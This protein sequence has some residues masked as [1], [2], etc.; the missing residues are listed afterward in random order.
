MNRCKVIFIFPKRNEPREDGT[1]FDVFDQLVDSFNDA[2]VCARIEQRMMPRDSTNA[3][4]HAPALL[5]QLRKAYRE[6]VRVGYD[7]KHDRMKS[8]RKTINEARGKV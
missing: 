4:L 2:D 8:F 1:P 7:P 5:A 3:V 6:L